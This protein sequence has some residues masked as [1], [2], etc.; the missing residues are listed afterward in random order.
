MTTNEENRLKGDKVGDFIGFTFDGVHSS[1]FNL[2]RVSNGSRY[3]SNL[4][5]S[6][7][8]YTVQAE[9]KDGV[10]YFGTVFK[11]RQIKFSTAFDELDENTYLKMIKKFSAKKIS[12]LWFDEEPYK[13]YYVKLKTV[14]VIKK[15]CFDE[16]VGRNRIYR[17]EMDLDFAC[18]PSYALARASYVDQALP[19]DEF[20]IVKVEENSKGNT[21]FHNHYL[22]G[23]NIETSNE[24]SDENELEVLPSIDS[25]SYFKKYGGTLAE[26][27][28]Y[29]EWAAA[30]GLENSPTE[31]V[32]NKEVENQ[33]ETFEA[34]E[35]TANFLVYNP[36][37]K[38]ADIILTYTPIL[39]DENGG[40]ERKIKFPGAK[41]WFGETSGIEKMGIKEFEFASGEKIVIDSQKHLIQGID[42]NGNINVYNKYHIS[43]DFFHIPCLSDEE[44]I[45]LYITQNAGGEGKWEVEYNF[46]YM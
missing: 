46:Y 35:T 34:E 7:Q 13:V 40:A 26:S 31:E 10:Y 2:V 28:N 3:E 24:I 4:L 33:T 37:V 36:G 21:L 12:K 1:E 9:G 8:D 42:S 43:G 38:E 39:K 11:E 44:K 25:T 19:K 22:E 14:P 32:I 41:I 15:L 27:Y 17:G 5:P 29:N 45:S 23:D 30:S 20:I 18:Y 6:F 16:G